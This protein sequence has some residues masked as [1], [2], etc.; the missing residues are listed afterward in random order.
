MV[1]HLVTVEIPLQESPPVMQQV[2]EAALARQGIPLRWAVTAV[3]LERQLVLV[4][5]IVTTETAKLEMPPAL[6][7]A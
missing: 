6:A 7:L 4:E 2:I 3:D 1:T 5:A